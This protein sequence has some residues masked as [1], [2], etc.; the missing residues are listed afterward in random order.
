VVKRGRKCASIVVDTSPAGFTSP[1]QS[2]LVGEYCNQ[3]PCLN[4]Q[5]FAVFSGVVTLGAMVGAVSGGPLNDAIGRKGGL[6]L[7][8]VP[9]ILGWALQIFGMS[10]ME[11]VGGRALVGFGIGVISCVVPL[12]ISETAPNYLR[13]AL[14]GVHQL[15]ITMGTLGVYLLGIR[16]LQLTWRHLAMAG[17]VPALTLLITISMLPETPF[18]LAQSGRKE[19]AKR[20]LKTLRFSN[21]VESELENI[22]DWTARRTQG[23]VTVAHLCHSDVSPGLFVACGA[24]I[25][26]QASGI[27][28]IIFYSGAWPLYDTNIF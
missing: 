19:G 23:K 12:Y 1:A 9:L 14:G 20:A 7:S 24:M 22:T 2:L 6:Q 25:L 17:V 3:S 4:E 5:E 8:S 10:F 27:N 13:G 18:W 16:D 26:Q 15:M 21:D 28:C 11:L